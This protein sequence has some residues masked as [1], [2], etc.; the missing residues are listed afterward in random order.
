MAI[1]SGRQNAITVDADY[2]DFEYELTVN[3]TNS[4]VDIAFVGVGTGTP[5]AP[6]QEPGLGSLRFRIH[7]PALGGQVDLM[8]DNGP[9]FVGGLA[10]VGASTGPHRTR[11]VRTG[12]IIDFSFDVDYN[13]TFS[14][15]GS[16]SLDLTTE[17]TIKTA[18]DTESRMFFGGAFSSSSF[19]DISVVPEP[20]TSAIVTFALLAGMIF[21]RRLI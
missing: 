20:S 17:P 15:D 21:R 12:D 9:F 11:I 13:G 5:A 16:Y 8:F 3:I 6:N 19:D 4:P 2:T 10:N 1:G 7:S 14:A 18:L